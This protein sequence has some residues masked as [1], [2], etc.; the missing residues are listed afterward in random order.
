MTIASTTN[1]N[2][3]PG[4]GSAGPFTFN[5]RIF[6]ATDLRVIRRSSAGVETVL[7]YPA[8]YTVPAT[9]IGTTTGTLTLT[10]VLAVGETLVIR[11]VLPVT[12]LTDLANQGTYFPKNI[13]D[14]FDRQTAIDQQLKAQIDLSL[15][16]D[17]S[18]DPA[19]YDLK[20]KPG[21]AG[22]VLGLAS[23]GTTMQFLDGA[24]PASTSFL[25][26]TGS[27]EGVVVGAVSAIYRQTDGAN[28][29]TLWRKRTGS[30]NTGWALIQGDLALFNV[31]DYGV[32][33]D[34]ATDDRAALNT[35]ANTT[36]PA[37][38]GTAYFPP[39]TYK[40]ESALTFPRHVTVVMAAGAKF[41]SVAAVALTISGPFQAARERVFESLPAAGGTTA[42]AV[43]FPHG[44][45]TNQYFPEWWGAFPTEV[46]GTECSAKIVQMEAAVPPVA[47]GVGG[48]GEIVFGHGTYL[49]TNWTPTKNN[50]IVRGAGIFATSLKGSGA[51]ASVV[52]LD[53]V[54]RH[55][56]SQMN[57]DGNGVKANALKFLTVASSSCGTHLFEFVYLLGATTD[58][59]SMGD[60]VSV[61]DI[62]HITFHKCVLKSNNPSNS[63]FLCNGNNVLLVL[64]VEP[65]IGGPGASPYNVDLRLGEIMF[66]SP[67]FSGATTAD[68]YA[69]SG[70]VVW[71]G[72]HTESAAA[73]VSLVGDPQNLSSGVHTLRGISGSTSGTD[74]VTHAALR[75]LVMEAC[76]W[77]GNVRTG[78]GASL[79][80][81]GNTFA[82][83]KGYIV[84]ALARV[85]GL[86]QNG[87]QYIKGIDSTG[88][89]AF[90]ASPAYVNLASLATQTVALANGLLY[91]YDASN[92][93]AA[94]VAI[95][96][97]TVTIIWQN[98]AGYSTVAS[99]ADK[100]NVYLVGANL[101]IQ[102]GYA[103]Q[104]TVRAVLTRLG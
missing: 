4:A 45:P 62:S 80:V 64:F 11:R 56:W 78:P 88:A 66:T 40:V 86:Q 68:I 14:Q 60:G 19:D 104:I 81:L 35:L 30:G 28:G 90:D 48:G 17:E 15:R 54:A 32:L 26:G 27:P 73:F 41:A 74:S 51:G 71:D 5:F 83:G 1:R 39:G 76:Y 33:G 6:A 49:I 101:V 29:K 102:N 37:T 24:T 9:A 46:G 75:M 82:A 42:L 58:T 47:A 61:D 93:H 65:I 69:R 53:G 99:T 72:G 20:F 70:H 100:V 91:I 8:D 98:A 10:T 57:I 3:Y 36:I 7:A 23:D 77:N 79:S 87:T 67:N 89:A 34:G 21:T 94:L 25:S 50:L 85:Y 2:E 96:N 12:Q 43:S 38:G 31:K 59:L 44:S 22:Q 55:R 52:T 92:G 84:E 103:A 95:Y 16:L 97:G 18:Y 13:E 63:Q